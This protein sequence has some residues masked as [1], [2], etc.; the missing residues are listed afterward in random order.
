MKVFLKIVSPKS[1]AS[2]K[3]EFTIEESNSHMSM[4]N[5]IQKLKNYDAEIYQ[6]ITADDS[7]HPNYLCIVNNEMLTYSER[8]TYSLKDGDSITIS[9]AIGGG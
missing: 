1:S 6:E 3:K 4:T 2:L 7:I 8:K 9:F 5:L